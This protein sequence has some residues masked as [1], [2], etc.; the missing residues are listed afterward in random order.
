MTIQNDSYVS[1]SNK[2]SLMSM[3]ISSSTCQGSCP[4]VG[5]CPGLGA[6]ACTGPCPSIG[7]CPSVGPCPSVDPSMDLPK[8]CDI[9][10][11]TH[12]KN[13]IY[14]LPCSCNIQVCWGCIHRDY[15]S[16]VS[17]G[18]K[19]PQCRVDTRYAVRY[20][21]MYYNKQLLLQPRE[22]LKYICERMD[23][24]DNIKPCAEELQEM[25]DVIIGIQYLKTLDPNSKLQRQFR[26]DATIDKLDIPVWVHK[27]RG[28]LT[29]FKKLKLIKARD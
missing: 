20:F 18:S 25:A 29:R 15:M 11:E 7:H 9:C 27:K 24:I 21:H 8:T 16:P 12:S 10:F 19:C 17:K 4:S 13:D 2:Q 23:I 6:C 28:L 14:P 26:N 5:P 22:G 1:R 3:L